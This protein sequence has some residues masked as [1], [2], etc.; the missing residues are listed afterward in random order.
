MRLSDPE[1]TTPC[2]LLDRARL[3]RNAARLRQ[4]FE[5]TGTVLRP[6]L[7]T[8]KSVEAAR[9]LLPTPK[10]PATVSTLAEAERF[11][12]AGITDLLYAVGI[13]PQKIARVQR[14]R[15]AGADLKVLVDNEVSAKAIATEAGASGRAIPT[16]I[17]I[18]VDG[19]R[20]GVAPD[21]EETLLQL[22]ALLDEA[23]CLAGILTH[24]GESYRSRNREEASRHA[25]A[26]RDDTVRLARL[27]E[28]NGFP[29]PIVSVGSTPTALTMSEPEGVTEVR[30]GVYAFCDLFQA[31]V[32]VCG[33]DDIALSVLTTVIGHQKSRG[34]TIID[35][36]WMALSPDRSTA[37]QPVDRFFG[38]VCDEAG[39]PLD[40]LVVSSANQEHGIVT[41]WPGSDRPALELPV[42]TR[43]RVLPNHACATAAQHEA[44]EVLGPSGEIE[45]RWPRFGG[46]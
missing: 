19:H 4:R 21:D 6:H 39:V 26:E 17:E 12:G 32:G 22:A 36:G 15:E 41:A 38:L 43:L 45:E 10:G 34:W 5:G 46:W 14:L 27:L 37:S 13:A 35:A 11:A 7:K 24:A 23:D 16:L 25:V 3:E 9:I 2:L 40:D 1:L 28:Q 31:G 33:V 30:A 8:V 44:Y 20:S 29:C 42:G 18:D